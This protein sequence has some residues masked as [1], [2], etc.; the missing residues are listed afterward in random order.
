MKTA[1]IAL[2]VAVA[3]NATTGCLLNLDGDRFPFS[4]G[5]NISKLHAVY[6]VIFLAYFFNLS[7]FIDDE[8]L[9][10]TPQKRFI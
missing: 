2:A 4:L 7:A 9:S 5:A 8:D 3:T 6:K 1:A 10:F